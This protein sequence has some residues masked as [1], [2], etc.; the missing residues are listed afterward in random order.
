MER[1]GQN[2]ESVSPS[3]EAVVVVEV[4]SV[5]VGVGVDSEPSSNAESVVVVVVVVVRFGPDA[6]V[7]VV[8]FGSSSSSSSNAESVV[9]VVV[10][11]RGGVGDCCPGG[12]SAVVVVV[13]GP[14]DPFGVAV[15][16]AVPVVVVGVAVGVDVGVA[17]GV[18]VG[19]AVGVGVCVGV[20]E[21]VAVALVGPAAPGAMF[22]PIPGSI[23]NAPPTTRN[24]TPSASRTPCT[25]R[26]WRRGA[27]TSAAPER[28]VTYRHLPGRTASRRGAGARRERVAS[29][30]TTTTAPAGII[31][32][33][34]ARRNHGGTAH[35]DSGVHWS[36]PESESS[37]GDDP[38]EGD[39]WSRC[40]RL[41]DCPWRRSDVRRGAGGGDGTAAVAVPAAGDVPPSKRPRRPSPGRPR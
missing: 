10:A 5:A 22:P 32:D 8:E 17:V 36:A 21:A 16:V 24:V 1:T 2:G 25:A 20:G 26:V 38:D 7:V 31:I 6:V 9:V 14:P 29:L 28:A 30:S 13:G 37:D 12:R 35:R 15:R 34:L 23:V 27:G 41:R 3:F 4:V 19:V 39:Q 18:D 33:W 11:V 40:R